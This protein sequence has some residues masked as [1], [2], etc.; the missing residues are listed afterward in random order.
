MPLG[1]VVEEQG[2][3]RESEV[4]GNEE[5]NDTVLAERLTQRGAS[6]GSSSREIYIN[7]EVGGRGKETKKR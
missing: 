4:L 6:R 1:A 7:A 2:G 5:I 3:K